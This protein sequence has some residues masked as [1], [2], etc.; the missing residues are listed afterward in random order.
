MILAE[1]KGK[2]KPL[3]R[4]LSPPCPQCRRENEPDAQSRRCHAKG[5]PRQQSKDRGKYRGVVET[6]ARRG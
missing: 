5:N 2:G 6:G 1:P 4:Q 3:E